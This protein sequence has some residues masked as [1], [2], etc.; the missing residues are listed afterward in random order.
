[1]DANPTFVSCPTCGYGT[2]LTPDN[3]RAYCPHCGRFFD[4]HV[5]QRI[6]DDSRIHHTASDETKRRSFRQRPPRVKP[7]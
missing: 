4:P 3:Q 5:A 6:P 7:Q 1:M 2:S